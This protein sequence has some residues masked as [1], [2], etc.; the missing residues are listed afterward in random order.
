MAFTQPVFLLLLLL[1]PL[2]AWIARPRLLHR[3]RGARRA[4]I[5]GSALVALVVRSMLVC[6]IVFA[7]A[8]MQAVRTSNELAIVFLVDASDSI[9][10]VAR[11]AALDWV[12]N[13][14]AAMRR[15]G[16]DEAAVVVFG[17]DAQVAR[18]L[19]SA[20]DLA[21]LDVQLRSSSTDVEGALRLGLSL[22]PEGAGRRVVLL[23]DGRQ[24]TGDA[25]AAARLLRTADVELDAV[26]LP[27]FDGPDA[28]VENIEAPQR[29]AVDAAIPLRVTV[30]ANRAQRAQLAVFA[31]DRLLERRTV[32]LLVGRNEFQ[33]TARADLPGFTALRVQVA[34]ADDARPQND[35]L[36]VGVLVEGPPRVLIVRA[37]SA[38]ADEGSA[39]RSALQAAGYVVDSE[40]AG[41]MP[42]EPATL[43]A[44]RSVLLVNVPARELSQ[45]T[46]LALQSYV[47][48]V[49]GGLVVVGGPNSYGV[50]GYFRTP[51]E[52]MLPVEVQIKDPSRF[53]ALSIVI[54]LDKSGS[55]STTENG[56]I[57][58][59][60][61]AEAAARVAELVKDEDEVTVIGFDTEPVDVIGPFPGVD[62]ERY[63]PQILKI[64]PGGGGIYARESLLE[65]Q[66]VTQ[67]S[68]RPNRFV[69]LLA[70]GSDV[71]R[72]EGV[73]DMVRRMQRDENTTL[74]VVAIGDGPDVPFLEGIAEAGKGRFHLTN[75]AANL[76]TIFSEEA[77]I[78]QRSYIVEREFTAARDAASPILA[79]IDAAPPLFG[80]V[81]VSEKEAA[82]VV[83]RATGDDPLLATWQYGLGRVAAFTSDA[84]GRWAREWVR[85]PNFAR[86]WAQIAQWTILERP[87]SNLQ[88][89]L[90]PAGE[91]TTIV[92]ETPDDPA[93]SPA[94]D[95]VLSAAFTDSAG[96]TF[97]QTLAQAAPARY[98]ADVTLEPAAAY[99]VR[100]SAPPAADVLL[101]YVAP[102]SPEYAPTSGGEPELRTWA[103]LGGGRLLNDPAQ[104]WERSAPVVAARDDLAP[105]LLMLAA[106]LLPFDI[107]VRRVGG[108]LREL[109]RRAQKRRESAPTTKP[110]PTPIPDARPV[111]VAPVRITPARPL[112]PPAPTSA[113]IGPRATASGAQ[114]AAAA[115]GELRRRRE[116]RARR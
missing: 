4:T 74:T 15:D 50:G 48:D 45:R 113:P 55:M 42:S 106:L 37:S 10:G 100:V 63:V 8:G 1:L 111:P 79:G 31:G 80:Y 105:T 109:L 23:S 102:Y 116:E 69:I 19:S 11:S 17:T 91:R 107:G 14:L 54:V 68:T 103:E 43:A 64:A 99:F 22:V 92:V 33:F 29:V 76:P 96:R 52:E 86:F 30:R 13:A 26:R 40:F 73:L 104:A 98:E 77:A 114:G 39:L 24:T 115:T 62:R 6:C 12:R 41:A 108:G 112:T 85:W 53:P 59:R 51:L 58:M 16:S 3:A 90:R 60:L 88:V 7:L 34:A 20:P 28:A 38:A 66:R 5:H 57:K 83:L 36:G 61:A 89:S 27:A 46:M 71:E 81:A 84:T 32:G 110:R 35:A 67:R 21:P 72:Q 75:Q 49:G 82:Q 78:A 93:A 56:V 9:G 25:A 47:R 65:A 95:A 70:D 44:Y 2:Y 97:T 101:P 87:E 18:A 94:A